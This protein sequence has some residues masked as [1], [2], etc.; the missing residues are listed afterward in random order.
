MSGQALARPPDGNSGRAYHR[1]NARD[2]TPV[3]ARP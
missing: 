2:Q 3:N 1:F